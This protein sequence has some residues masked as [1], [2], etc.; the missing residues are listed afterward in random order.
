MLEYLDAASL[1]MMDVTHQA[2]LIIEYEGDV[3][4]DMTGALEEESWFAMSA[5]DRAEADRI[6]SGETA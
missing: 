2:A 6:S 4:L 5:A 1:K 3:D